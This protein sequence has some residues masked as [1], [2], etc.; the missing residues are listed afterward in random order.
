MRAHQEGSTENRES[1]EEYI[2]SKE[3][4]Y[5]E[6]IR[7]GPID[8][9][10]DLPCN[11]R[12]LEYKRGDPPLFWLLRF[13]HCFPAQRREEERREKRRREKRRREKRRRERGEAE[14]EATRTPRRCPANQRDCYLA[15]ALPGSTQTPYLPGTDRHLV[16]TSPTAASTRRCRLYTYTTVYLP[17]LTGCNHSKRIKRPT[18]ITYFGHSDSEF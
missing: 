17:G 3:G 6:R 9:C 12:L 4:R 5:S 7:S 13:S 2:R 11:G 16:T 1:G 15:P 8:G 14:R 18:N 10:L